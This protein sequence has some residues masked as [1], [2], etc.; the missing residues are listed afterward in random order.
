MDPSLTPCI[1]DS[2]R[3]KFSVFLSFDKPNEGYGRRKFGA[4]NSLI[5]NNYNRKIF[6]PFLAN[7]ISNEIRNSNNTFDLIWSVIQGQTMICLVPKV[8]NKLNLE[9]VVEIWDP[10]EWWLDENHFDSYSYHKVMKAFKRLLLNAKCCLAASHNMAKEYKEKYSAVCVP[11]IPSLKAYSPFIK[12]S[13][14]SEFHIGYS[15][16][17]YS[18]NEFSAFID[19]LDSIKW[20]YQGKRIILYVFTDYID[21]VI[22]KQHPNIKSSGWI[23]QE[24]LLKRL[25]CMDL[26]YCPY[27]F[28]KKF[29]VIARL[30]FP[31]KLT[32]YLKSGV[33]V[34]VHAPVYSSISN[35][36]KDGITGYV[37][38]TTNIDDI[39]EKVK[40]IINDGNRESIGMNGYQLFLKFLTNETM[41]KSFYKSLGMRDTNY[42][43]CTD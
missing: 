7:K 1:P 3:E 12:K 19:S 29:E 24:E 11:V 32:S 30:S 14:N 4:L 10:P 40:L 28:D 34:L 17:I 27:R 16:Q 33:P 42:E 2:I 39:A 15:G 41:K 18:K 25:S 31:S 35:F 20:T 38:N 22:L 43:H 9:Y 6:L 5:F 8:A 36:I 23:P 37:C 13:D 26:C 21:T